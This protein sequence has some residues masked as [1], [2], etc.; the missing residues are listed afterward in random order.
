MKKLSLFFCL[1]LA[2]MTTFQAC[3]NEDEATPAPEDEPPSI[4]NL[5][6][7][8]FTLATGATETLTIT[9]AHFG[10]EQSAVTVTMGGSSLAV[11]SVTDTR[12]EA[13]VTANTTSGT[14]TVT[15][16]DQSATSSESVTINQIPVI[17]DFNPK[18]GESGTEVT[19]TGNNFTADA[20]VTF[21]IDQAATVQFVSA[22]ELKATV[23]ADAETG[24]IKVAIG[25]AEV[26]TAT[27]FEVVILNQNEVFNP[28]TGKVWMDRN[29]GA[30]QV[31]TSSTDAA[32]YGD[33]YQW[34]RAADGHESRTSG[35]AE[36]LAT[37]DTPGHG[38][39]ITNGVSI[40]YD[41]RNP[42]ND[43]LWQGVNGTNNPCPSGYRLPTEAEWEAERT[44][45]SSDDAAGA[46]ASPLKLPVAGY[47]LNNNGSFYEV[48]SGGY[49]WSSTVSG[50]DA[51]CLYFYSSSAFM[52]S[53]YRARGYSVRCLKD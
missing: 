6:P 4:T 5:S 48:G 12:I 47:R 41:W 25:N 29:L 50:T 14:V 53:N 28:T 7:L 2:L 31:A 13:D 51:R 49:Y 34:G 24:K 40:P 22:T 52:L 36:I 35:T 3:N 1:L 44:S 17:S 10:T 18:S 30:S 43:N 32:A 11:Q 9:G 27:D 21:A 16:N 37:S 45:W 20:V 19:I 39:F 46:F 26:E 23:P 33:L 15:V 38:D 42:Q 8:E